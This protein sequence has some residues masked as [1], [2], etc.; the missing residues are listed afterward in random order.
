MGRL[1]IL[2]QAWRYLM[3]RDSHSECRAALEHERAAR[4]WERE[5]FLALVRDL[6]AKLLEVA[7]PGLNHRLQPRP[8]APPKPA[9]VAIKPQEPEM[10]PGIG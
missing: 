5:S 4:Q 2:V 8:V 10:F 6:Q 1:G 9:P 7:D 3:A